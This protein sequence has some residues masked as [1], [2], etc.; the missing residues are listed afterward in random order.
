MAYRSSLFIIE[1]TP[2]PVVLNGG[3]AAGIIGALGE[4]KPHRTESGKPQKRG[5]Q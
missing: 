5:G 1:A 3:A 2:P 4:A